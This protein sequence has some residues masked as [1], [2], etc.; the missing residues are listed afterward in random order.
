MNDEIVWCGNC[1]KFELSTISK[2]EITICTTNFVV[3]IEFVAKRNKWGIFTGD[4]IYRWF[5]SLNSS[6]WT[7]H[8]QIIQYNWILITHKIKL[9]EFHLLNFWDISEWSFVL[10]E[11]FEPNLSI[12]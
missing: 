11:R 8:L 4:L 3:Q 10:F 2:H 6:I 12:F 7:D 9:K 1:T 5:L